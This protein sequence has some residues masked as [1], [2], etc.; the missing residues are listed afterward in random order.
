[1]T[2]IAGVEVGATHLRVFVARG[3]AAPMTFET[4]W[5]RGSIDD[6]VDAISAKCGA[7]TSVHL[8]IGLAHLSVAQV[9][10]PPVGDEAQRQMLLLEPDRWFPVSVDAAL[11]VA[12]VAE[13]GVTFAADAAFVEDCVAAFETWA[14]VRRIDAAPV[15][16]ARASVAIREPN[17]RIGL[18]ASAGE[19]GDVE[20][21]DGVVSQVRRRRI[22]ATDAVPIQN[23]LL[24]SVADE[25]YAVAYGVTLPTAPEASD[26]LFTAELQRR[27]TT[28]SRRTLSAWIA[29]AVLAIAASLWAADRSRETTLATLEGAITSER[30]A[31]AP[32]MTALTQALSIDRELRAVRTT[33]ADRDDILS[34]M[35]AIGARLPLDAV[36]QR[37]RLVGTE[38]QIEGNAKTAATVLARLASES[39][40][41]NVR[42][43]APSS[44]F[45]DGT[46]DRETFAIA[47]SLR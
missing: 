28:R 18:E 39:R 40:F 37:V 34:A 20:L 45:R 26:G 43:L 23:H 19:I 17:A 27:F 8:A 9:S 38:W 47:F 2:T 13:T 33:V 36:A 11:A 24:R 44:R 4:P 41:E 10:L 15:A 29:A 46:T 6:A 1:V 12:R 30:V 42:F 16:I 3:G 31:A 25:Q 32:G 14:P 35:A 7:V 5:Q 22:G 21:R